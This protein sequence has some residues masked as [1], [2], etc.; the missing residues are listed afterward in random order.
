MELGGFSTGLEEF[1]ENGPVTV[2]CVFLQTFF[3]VH[4]NVNECVCVL[5]LVFL[6]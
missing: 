6:L 2:S 5:V 4:I 1:L 3:Y